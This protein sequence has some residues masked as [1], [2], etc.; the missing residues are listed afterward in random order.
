[1]KLLLLPILICLN[2]T[3]FGQIN[4]ESIFADSLSSE[5]S[6]VT[7]MN[8]LL[9]HFEADIV[10][11]KVVF[12]ANN[13]QKKEAIESFFDR[14]L[15]S[16]INFP[17]KEKGFIYH[18]KGKFHYDNYQDK[19]ALAAYQK[20]A[21]YRKKGL[22]ENDILIAKS[23]YMTAVC[24][25][26]LEELE[27]AKTTLKAAEKIYSFNNSEKDKVNCQ[28]RLAEIYFELGDFE[29]TLIYAKNAIN[30]YQKLPG[31]NRSKLAENNLTLG[32]AYNQLKRHNIGLEYVKKAAHLKEQ[33][34]AESDL[35]VIVYQSF[36]IESLL[37]L[38]RYDEALNL[39]LKSEKKLLKNP[40]KNA[41]SLLPQLYQNMAI[42]CNKKRD[43]GQSFQYLDKATLAL[44]GKTA[45]RADTSNLL[46]N[47]GSTSM[48][49]GDYEAALDYFQKTIVLLTESFDNINPFS[50]PNW[51]AEPLLQTKASLL[52][53]L[54]FKAQTFFKLYQKNQEEKHLNAAHQTYQSY[55]ELVDLLRADFINQGSK[56]FWLAET[57][58]AFENALEVAFEL[59]QKAGK[60]RYAQTIF[61]L[62]EQNKSVLLL[63]SLQQQK[64]GILAGIPDSLLQKKKR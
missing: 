59:Y 24:H 36:V 58:P 8:G 42:T 47:F 57:Y 60:K 18:E 14:I 10:A 25:T 9:S 45:S 11:Q 48:L 1:M 5:N 43:F 44:D 3:L 50:N 12:F 23:L 13:L 20:A 63:E 51:H 56:L 6:F 41:L 46:H 33:I 32:R 27:A 15:A 55:S 64:E 37:G 53:T 54:D 35:Q 49:N 7:K 29:T 22:P 19:K 16:E 26:Y 61:Q 4:M 17:D 21:D 2:W 62:M 52:K 39:Y 38:K 28:A 30:S 31:D 40:D 34:V